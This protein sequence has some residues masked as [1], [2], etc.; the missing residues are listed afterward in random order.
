M[1]SHNALA[2]K[3]NKSPVNKLPVRLYN[4]QRIC[5]GLPVRRWT[6]LFFVFLATHR[7]VL[8]LGQVFLYSEV[9][10]PKLPNCVSRRTNLQVKK[11]RLFGSRHST[12]PKLVLFLF[13][14]AF[15]FGASAA[16]GDS[17]RTGRGECES[18]LEGS[19]AE[20]AQSKEEESIGGLCT[21]FDWTPRCFLAT[22]LRKDVGTNDH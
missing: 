15:W 1:F 19:G 8:A 14:I 3:V 9:T 13:F 5:F 22:D 6:S 7:C 20:E 2:T 12:V 21:A 18:W 16:A 17:D 11:Y 4:V 10:N